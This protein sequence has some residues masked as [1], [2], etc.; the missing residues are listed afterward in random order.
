MA[1]RSHVLR[2]FDMARM[3]NRLA[4]LITLAA[5][6]A[7]VVLWFLEAGMEVFWAPVHAFVGW[8]L[9]REI[10]PDH[11]WTAL[12]AAILAAVWVLVG[13]PMSALALVG[14][15]VA[16]RLVLN[17]TGRRPLATDLA[18]LAAVATIISITALGW[19]G[20][21]GLA[22]A[23]YI[24]ERMAKEHNTTALFAAAAG[25]LGASAVATL[26]GAFPRE[27][28]PVRPLLVAAAGILA[29][30]TVVREPEVPTSQVDARTKEFLEP[31]RLH[32]SRGMVGVLVFVASVLAGIDGAAVVPLLVTL[33]L[34][35]AS[36][37][38]ERIRRRDT[39]SP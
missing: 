19:V 31:R 37:E 13:T 25:A 28:P 34:V 26:A 7:A 15:M 5:G 29:L 20:G 27:L 21:F 14:M 4:V 10:D 9:V 11:D 16:A 30:L 35:L 32:A 8:A 33:A 38:L 2:P 17:S 12:V 3:S 23:I 6:I 24:D 1:F 18:M 22:V 36:N 39:L